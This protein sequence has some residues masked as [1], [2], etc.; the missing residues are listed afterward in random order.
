MC[1]SLHKEESIDLGELLEAFATRPRSVHWA[2]G[3]LGASTDSP[4]SSMVDR[5]SAQPTSRGASAVGADTDPVHLPVQAVRSGFGA[6]TTHA[7]D[8]VEA[9]A[10]DLAHAV[11]DTESPLAVRIS[12]VGSL[13]DQSAH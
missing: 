12:R 10:P 11:F 9:P 13:V 7:N 5:P 8:R 4:T 3:D 2:I 6:N 1:L